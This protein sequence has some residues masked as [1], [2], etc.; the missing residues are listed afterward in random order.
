MSPKNFIHVPVKKEVIDLLNEC[1]T[2]YRKHHP[3]LD[4][5]KLSK[6]RLIKIVCEW[7][8]K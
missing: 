4:D 5:F 6:H 7:Y 3:E 2:L 1:E 8:L